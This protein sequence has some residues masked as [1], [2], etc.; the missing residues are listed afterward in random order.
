MFG[1]PIP[2]D[3]SYLV[4]TKAFG[5]YNPK[6]V[7]AITLN[8]NRIPIIIYEN[9]VILECLLPGVSLKKAGEIHKKAKQEYNEELAKGAK[10][11]ADHQKKI[12]E[13]LMERYQTA[14][15]FPPIIGDA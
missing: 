10:I 5:W 4:Y 13:E 6:K 15:P 14:M 1:H 3:E 7:L 11:I 8:K 9:K 12:Q 2:L